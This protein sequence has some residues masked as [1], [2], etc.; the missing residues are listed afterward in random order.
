MLATFGKTI[1]LLFLTLL[2]A[3]CAA[4]P[5]R[6]PGPPIEDSIA[7][8]DQ[9]NCWCGTLRGNGLL[10]PAHWSSLA[11]LTEFYGPPAALV[12]GSSSSITMLLLESILMNPY[13]SDQYFSE[14]SPE[15]YHEDVAFLLK[16][17]EPNIIKLVSGKLA[18]AVDILIEDQEVVMAKVDTLRTKWERGG[19]LNYLGIAKAALF[20]K[21]IS[22]LR[23]IVFSKEFQMVVNTDFFIDYLK[24][25]NQENKTY[26][27]N[28]SQAQNEIQRFELTQD[29]QAGVT[30]RIKQ[31]GKALDNIG[32]YNAHWDSKIFFRPS[33]IQ[34]D[35]LVTL[36]GCV[37]N[38]YSGSGFEDYWTRTRFNRL[39]ETCARGSRGKTW[40]QIVDEQP[41]CREIMDD[42]ARSWRLYYA[43]HKNE[44]QQRMS[45]SI[46]HSS[47]SNRFRAFPL[48]ALLMGPSAEEYLRIKSAYEEDP[49]VGRSG[50]ISCRQV[51]FSNRLLGC[52]TRSDTD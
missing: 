12:G 41:V 48:T 36:F 26:A 9:E 28:M 42:T 10:V 52:F 30:E 6:H 39:M 15:A 16:S 11:R 2:L 49:A 43:M 29:Y 14:T 5:K 22:A 37:A 31:L 38:F 24:T 8:Y 33:L 51:R 25:N 40:R 47:I 13:F 46:S 1:F 35:G 17:I 50:T 34:H 19:F 21:H 23:K 7:P 32:N 3:G 44:L 27:T 20:D 4:Y 18:K 45:D